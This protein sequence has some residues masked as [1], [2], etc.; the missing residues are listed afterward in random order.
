ME[1]KS[2]IIEAIKL[3]FIMYNKNDLP[4]NE[5]IYSLSLKI[6]NNC[7]IETARKIL[8]YSL[9]REYLK[10][11]GNTIITNIMIKPKNEVKFNLDIDFTKI[12]NLEMAD[13]ESLPP[14]KT[15][16]PVHKKV[17]KKSVRSD[18]E[19]RI[20]SNVNIKSDCKG[21]KEDKSKFKKDIPLQKKLKTQQ[22][23]KST[24]TEKTLKKSK[25]KKKS[26][27]LDA[28]FKK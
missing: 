19:K 7:N 6:I 4:V 27:T 26:R 12:E 3:P 20:L 22:E 21:L 10:R 13:L 14:I 16:K 11:E 17:E 25:I 1:G 2:S 8:Q 15:F 24:K 5:Y 9:K 28:F 23:E 18:I